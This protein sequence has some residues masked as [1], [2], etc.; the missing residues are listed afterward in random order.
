MKANVYLRVACALLA[1]LM[2]AGCTG[3]GTPLESDSDL[4][5][6]A[7][8]AGATDA[9]TDAL[10]EPETAPINPERTETEMDIYGDGYNNH[11]IVGF[12]EQGRSIPAVSARREDEDKQVG[13]FYH[14]WLGQ[15]DTSEI[16]HIPTI[17]EELGDHALFHEDVPDSPAWQFH[18]WETP[19]YGY[20]NSGDDWVI[21]RHMEML[22]EAG[23][24]FLCFDTTNA[25]IYQNV[26]KRIMRV[27]TELREAGWDAPQVTWYTHSRSVETA[28]KIYETFYK[29][30]TYPESWY[31]VDGKP[32]IIAY[33]DGARDKAEADSRG[34]TSFVPKDMSQEMQDYFYIRDP[35]WPYDSAQPTGWPYTDW[36][37]PQPLNGG[38]MVS[39]SL[40]SHTACPFSFSV[41]RAGSW[42]DNWG[43]GW[44]TT[45]KVNVEADIMKGTFF[46]SQWKVAI[47]RDPR[48]VMVTGW[49]EWVAQKNLYD[50]E[51]AFVDNFDMQYS[52][53]A[54]PMQ[55]G[56]EDAYFIQL[57][58]RIRAFK[59]VSMDGKIASTVKKTIDVAGSAAQ[60]S[61]VNAVYRRVGTDDGKRGAYDAAR[62]EYYEQEPVR[63][64]FNEIRVTVDKE[65]IYFYIRAE[66]DIVLSDDAN[67]MNIFIGLGSTPTMKGWESYEF[68]IN[69]S[70]TGNTAT[71]EKLNADYTGEA[72]EAV[73]TYSV[74]GNV[75]QLSVPRAALGL[76]NPGDFYFKVADGVVDTDE[77]MDYYITGR[78]M[79]MGRL[80]YLYQIGNLD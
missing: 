31:C 72:L 30:E 33:T 15:H 63:N 35:E 2:L 68:V 16:Y 58:E 70:R 18:W 4:A 29:T 53:D 80:S 46:D 64:N 22:T 8:T 5:T 50:G 13:I 55:G 60:W 17:R 7:L 23:I 49:N 65:N 28:E 79:P 14:I 34:D 78:S 27:I 25:L 11:L 41:S 3:A 10:T 62:K 48:F 40:A 66:E 1:S 61:D 57:I 75:M 76:E 38:D 19:L 74:Q 45:N 51:Y 39:V 42:P 52:R 67:W 37:Y 71:I 6:H 9:P 77:I 54:E 36:E 59:Y 47:K 26:A 12:N 44:D 56:Y 20:Y 69:R 24:D 43:R 32:M 73:A 21:R